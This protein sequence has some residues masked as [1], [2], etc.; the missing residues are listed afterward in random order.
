MWDTEGLR[1][2]VCAYVDEARERGEPVERVIVDLKQ[3]MEIGGAWRRTA[4]REMEMLAEGVIRWCI[5]RYY[6]PADVR[7]PDDV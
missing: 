6:Q 1:T 7:P 2:A 4:T 5:D 3:M